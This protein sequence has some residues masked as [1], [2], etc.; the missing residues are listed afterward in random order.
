MCKTAVKHALTAA[1]DKLQQTA[2]EINA[3]LSKS[4]YLKMD[5]TP[6][7]FGGRRQYV[8][9]C[10]GDAGV[11]VT[12]DTREAAEIDYPLSIL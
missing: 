5:A 7:R 4:R 1:S 2:D 6:I 10:V 8:W 3:S 9:A 11:A 12:V